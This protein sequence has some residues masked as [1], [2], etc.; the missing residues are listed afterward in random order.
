MTVLAEHVSGFGRIT[1]TT[2]I[3]VLITR[4]QRANVFEA[5]MVGLGYILAGLTFDLLVSLR[6]IRNQLYY[7]VATLITGFIAVIPYWLSKIYFL[8][9][10]GF[11]LAFPVYLY[12]GLKGVTLS[13][14]GSIVGVSVNRSLT[15][16]QKDG[17][18]TD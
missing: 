14:V 8:G 2:L 7:I 10:G 18:K 16:I 4:L 17:R 11:I 9:V 12:S 15:L 3:A 1:L 13:V 6:R 5:M